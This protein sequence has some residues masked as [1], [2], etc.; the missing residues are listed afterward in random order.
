MLDPVP[1]S[2]PKLFTFVNRERFTVA[3]FP[4]GNVRGATMPSVL[5]GP[6]TKLNV[7]TFDVGKY[8]KGSALFAG[9]ATSSITTGK[10]TPVNTTKPVVKSCAG[11]V[12]PSKK[13]RE[14]ISVVVS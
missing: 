7:K 13:M 4:K 3:H 14:T 12:L 9:G 10:S 11:T 8:E 5:W 1:S 2:T 6:D